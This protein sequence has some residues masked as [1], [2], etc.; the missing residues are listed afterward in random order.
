MTSPLPDLDPE[1]VALYM[2][3]AAMIMAGTCLGL[4]GFYGLP[5]G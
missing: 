3:L 5:M 1:N 2:A 4:H